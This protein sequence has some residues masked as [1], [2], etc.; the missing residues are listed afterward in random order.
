MLFLA[1]TKESKSKATLYF[2]SAVISLLLL[3]AVCIT[4][5]FNYT[6]KQEA[7]FRMQSAS[8]RETESLEY[9]QTISGI[10][11]SVISKPSAS[12]KVYNKDNSPI[13]NIDSP[14]MTALDITDSIRDL[15]RTYLYS[16]YASSYRESW[17][18]KVYDGSNVEWETAIVNKTLS[19][20]IVSFIVND[21]G[22]EID[23]SYLFPISL[24]IH[25]SFE[26]EE[27]LA[28]YLSSK[29]CCG[30]TG[31]C[32]AANNVFGKTLSQLPK[33]KMEYLIYMV[34]N[35]QNS[36]EDYL[37]D[38]EQVDESIS[39][40]DFGLRD[41]SSKI[42]KGLEYS[43]L[44]EM[45]AL[46]IP[47]TD[48]IH[49]Y[50][51]IDSEMQG[52]LQSMVD[53][54]LKYHIELLGSNRTLWDATVMVIDGRTGNVLA[55]VVS[56]SVNSSGN[57]MILYDES[58]VPFYEEFQ[59]IL[60]TEQINKDSLVVVDN[61][62]V[63]IPDAVNAGNFEWT[64]LEVVPDKVE[65]I[66]AAEVM[67]YASSL[68][69]LV[70]CYIKGIRHVDKTM[71]LSESS[72]SMNLDMINFLSDNSDSRFWGFC[73]LT[74]HGCTIVRGCSSWIA[75]CSVGVTATGNPLNNAEK[76]EC[77]TIAYSVI[78][79]LEQAFSDDAVSLET[80][81]NFEELQNLVKE[82]NAAVVRSTLERY[83]DELSS[84]VLSSKQ[85]V[86]TWESMYKDIESELMS[87]RKYIPEAL[88]AELDKKLKDIRVSKTPKLIECS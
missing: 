14:N 47:V 24:S 22:M 72:R 67:K 62:L 8:N 18:D 83:L 79:L 49:V 73:M 44:S 70:P 39:E 76:L 28:F 9:T 52:A 30:Y 19:G 50:T 21:K 12:P 45:S 37:S 4:V 87:V 78:D 53:S 3:G 84:F 77:S 20:L 38:S 36:F 46:G 10:I 59:S 48:N 60:A 42:Y 63:P 88:S 68:Y 40:S 69:N 86:L 17:Y 85:D 29:D 66:E 16:E 11:E 51:G 5:Y 61:S 58:N 33:V 82:D 26:E 13:F 75:V 43:I 71:F 74:E 15:C 35:P 57:R 55:D 80:P 34:A 6:E 54:L 41:N 81:S 7:A 1:K 25:E 2:I 27:L 23:D 56:R 65:T 31:I 32:S 64:S